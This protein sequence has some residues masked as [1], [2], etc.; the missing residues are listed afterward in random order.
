MFGYNKSNI[1]A[2]GKT[3]LDDAAAKIKANTDITLVV[4]TGHTD[5][6]GSYKY[7]QKL[8]E[9]RAKQVGDY[10]VSQGVDSAL[11]STTGRGESV[12]VVHCKG[13]RATKALISCLAPNRRVEIKAQARQEVGCK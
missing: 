1:A 3:A 13:S 8:S 12:P 9:R 7:N 10:L 6:T 11:I 2:A 4:V 5:R